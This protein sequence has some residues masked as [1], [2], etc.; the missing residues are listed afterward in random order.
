MLGEGEAFIYDCPYNSL[1]RQ[2]VTDSEGRV[3]EF[4]LSAPTSVINIQEKTGENVISIDRVVLVPAAQWS[5][6]L[7]TPASRCVRD[8]RT[9]ACVT[10]R[11]PYP[12]P[13][14]ESVI[15]VPQQILDGYPARNLPRGIDDQSKQLV[16][17]NNL[18]PEVNLSYNFGRFSMQFNIEF[19]L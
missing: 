8:P 19:Q 17:I 11:L 5:P 2:V 7:V 18:N 1:C 9:A 6:D 4:D 14:D 16:Y 15:S 3:L 12:P 10:P 13:P